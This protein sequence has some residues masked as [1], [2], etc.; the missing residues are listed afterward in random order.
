MAQ[1][2]VT[3]CLDAHSFL[4][5]S[6]A[7]TSRRQK[8]SVY[9]L[10]FITSLSC[11]FSH[12]KIRTAEISTCGRNKPNSIRPHPSYTQQ[13]HKTFPFWKAA[14][15]LH[16]A[17]P[18]ANNSASG[19]HLIQ[20]IGCA[21]SGAREVTHRAHS[22]ESSLFYQCGTTHKDLYYCTWI[23]SALQ[24][25]PMEVNACDLWGAIHG[26]CPCCF[27]GIT[28]VLAPVPADPV[29]P[30]A[31]FGYRSWKASCWPPVVFYAALFF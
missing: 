13:H 10:P 11:L 19:C 17:A 21:Y 8:Y 14:R 22:L 23:N 24:H 2:V 12:E 28:T 6:S 30:S 25:F 29:S 16:S 26:F 7:A 27:C 3:E 9:K 31:C 5:S 18:N 20:Q 15:V 1:A 4:H